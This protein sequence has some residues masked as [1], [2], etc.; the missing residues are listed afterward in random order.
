MTI[1]RLE[2]RGE[3]RTVSEIAALTGRSNSWVRRNSDGVRVIEP[4]GAA[5]SDPETH[6]HWP[7][8]FH[9][10]VRDTISGWSRR[11][12]IPRSTLSR[13][14]AICR[15]PVKRALTEPVMGRSQ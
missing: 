3:Q 13:R 5:Y 1:R 8:Y 6:P 11:T 12:G 9:E 4:N 10:G 2:F 14:L 15:W 7:T